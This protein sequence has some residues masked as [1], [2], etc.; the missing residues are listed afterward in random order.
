M[1]CD[2]DDSHASTLPKLEEQPV[3][4]PASETPGAPKLA[5]LRERKESGEG[6]RYN[7]S[8]KKQKHRSRSGQDR[9]DARLEDQETGLSNAFF[10]DLR[11]CGALEQRL[12]GLDE[13]RGQRGPMLEFV[14]YP[15]RQATAWEGG[16]VLA[17]R[18]RDT[19]FFVEKI[20]GAEEYRNVPG[21]ERELP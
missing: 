10:E 17:E 2:A 15:Q 11:N 18:G 9:D 20:R 13:D 4:L 8:R 16:N 12:S 6:W 3:R 7:G 14:P 19:G 5:R 21:I 1:L